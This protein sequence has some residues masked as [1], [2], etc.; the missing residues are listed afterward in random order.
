METM[1][2]K[3]QFPGD[4]RPRARREGRVVVMEEGFYFFLNDKIPRINK[5]KYF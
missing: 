2:K 5:K 3:C 1:K 4:R